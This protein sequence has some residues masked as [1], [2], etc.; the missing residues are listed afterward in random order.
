MGKA[1]VSVPGRETDIGDKFLPLVVAGS[2]EAVSET[3]ETII[4]FPDSVQAEFPEFA[5]VQ[6]TVPAGSLYSDDSTPG[7]MVGIAPVDPARLPGQLPDDLQFALVITVQTDGATNFVVPVPACF[8]NLP[9]PITSQTL[10]AGAKSALWSFNHDTGFFE[11]RGSM[12][13]SAD[14]TMVCTDPGVG[15]TAPGWHASQ[16]GCTGEDG[17][18]GGECVDPSL[19]RILRSQGPC[20]LGPITVQQDPGIPSL[21]HFSIPNNYS[22][23]VNWSAPTGSATSVFDRFGP[24]FSAHF[25]ESGDHTVTV[26]NSLACPGFVPCLP[27]TKTFTPD[28]TPTELNLEGILAFR[29]DLLGEILEVGI[30]EGFSALDAQGNPFNNV[31][32]PILWDLGSAGLLLD[33]EFGGG[34]LRAK[35]CAVGQI[36]ITATQKNFCGEK[37][38]VRDIIVNPGQC[39]PFTVTPPAMIVQDTIASFQVQSDCTLWG[40]EFT[41]SFQHEFGATFTLTNVPG[42]SEFGPAGFSYV[43]P[44]V[45]SLPGNWSFSV[46]RTAQP[47]GNF[48]IRAGSFFVLPPGAGTPRRGAGGSPVTFFDADG[49]TIEPD[50]ETIGEAAS[51][52]VELNPASLETPDDSE[53]TRISFV[54]SPDSDLLPASGRNFVKI[55]NLNSGFITHREAG[56]GSVAFRRPTRLRANTPHRFEL[57]NV[58][59]LGVATVQLTTPGEGDRVEFVFSAS[60]VEATLASGAITLVEAGPDATLGTPDDVQVDRSVPSYRD[61]LRRFVLDYDPP[62]QTG[63]YRL[64]LNASEVQDTSGEGL[65]IDEISDFTVIALRLG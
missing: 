10:P 62:L 30:I 15:I 32:A 24:T 58:N 3:Q 21:Y 33:Q 51:K 26:S 20:T 18:V 28:A 2:L 34:T 53:A 56:S 59:T 49:N 17:D 31:D 39:G 16:T 61:D 27:A 6:I 1:W 64:T 57:L 35:F 14:A 43:L 8:P 45:F 19:A 52:F 5:M 38:V 25:C 60:I 11:V 54:L 55:T 7:G 4:D 47:C 42:E 22:G 63:S 41:W 50:G 36:R 37:V 23:L 13:V 46:S 12:T 65:L 44:A 9:D 29:P 40:D 48:V